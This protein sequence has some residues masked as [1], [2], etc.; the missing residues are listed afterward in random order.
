MQAE[1]AVKHAALILCMALAT[2]FPSSAQNSIAEPTSLWGGLAPG[3]YQVGFRSYFKFDHGRR[4]RPLSAE[5]EQRIAK[6][7]E[8][9]A[10]THRGRPAPD[11]QR[12]RI[13]EFRPVLIAIWYPASAT[14]SRMTYHDYFDVPH[15][16][17]LADFARR[18]KQFGEKTAKETVFR[19][20]EESLTAEERL[21]FNQLFQMESYTYRDAPAAAGRFPA[22]VYHPGAG[23]SFDENAVMSEFLA[24]HGYVI[25]SSAYQTST[26]QA[27]NNVGGASKSVRDMQFLL[28]A[29][30]KLPFVEITKIAGVGH[31]AGAQTLMQ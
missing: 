23:G 26:V 8:S 5:Q 12:D 31:S 27:S 15:L 18:L 17:E 21:A 29:A 7:L 6:L 24:S 2:L 16:D 11:R 20:K 10:P 9:P 22:V 1:Y 4:D 19:N 13:P 3:P 14:S 28:Q 30:S 25:L